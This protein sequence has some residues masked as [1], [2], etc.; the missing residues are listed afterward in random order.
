MVGLFDRILLGG[1]RFVGGCCDAAG[2]DS[3]LRMPIFLTFNPFFFFSA[4]FSLDRGELLRCVREDA[5]CLPLVISNE[6]LGLGSSPHPHSSSSSC[7]AVV[8]L[9]RW[10]QKCE[11]FRHS[12]IFRYLQ[13]LVFPKRLR[14]IP[15]ISVIRC[16]ESADSVNYAKQ[17]DRTKHH[18][19]Y[20]T[21]F[22]VDSFDRRNLRYIRWFLW[23]WGRWSHNCLI[24]YW[25]RVG[26]D[27]FFRW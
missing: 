1:F 10:W 23:R 6:G 26:F 7:G 13:A 22:I 15:G 24:G 19:W 27:R 25:R 5:E 3:G 12:K 14:G 9:N 21:V 2:I 16:C 11:I 17:D 18:Q 20:S 8:D 4:V